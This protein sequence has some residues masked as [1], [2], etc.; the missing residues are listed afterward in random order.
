VSVCLVALLGGKGVRV[1]TPF[2]NT[3][4][5]KKD[6]LSADFVEDMEVANTYPFEF[7]NTLEVS[8]MPSHKLPFKIGT[9]VMLQQNLDP[10][11]GLC[12]GMRLIA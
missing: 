8:G 6:F 12:N 5:K 11:A 10:S 3:F 4:Q 7:F 1:S 9:L 2:I